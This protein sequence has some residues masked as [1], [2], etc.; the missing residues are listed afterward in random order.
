[1]GHF[2]VIKGQYPSLSQLEETLAVKSTE[3]GIVRGSALVKDA[4]TWRRGVT[5]DS[6]DASTAGPVVYFALQNQ[7]DPD[8]VMAKKVTAIPCLAPIR[9]ETD[10]YAGSPTVGSFLTVNGNGTTTFGLVGAAANGDTACGIVTS[11]PT[12]RWS[13]NS[14]PYAGFPSPRTGAAINV[15]TFWCVYVPQVVI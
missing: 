9:V 3:T 10:Q 11:V 4:G 6:G 8:V 14:G 2:N 1:M 5:T 12:R 13:N 15:I 7:A